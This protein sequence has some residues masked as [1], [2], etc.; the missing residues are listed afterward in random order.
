MKMRVFAA[1]PVPGPIREQLQLWAEE[2]RGKTAF[3]KWVHP[4]DYH[5]T[6]QFLG[7]VG[8]AKLVE[9]RAALQ[10]VQAAPFTLRLHGAGLFGP[11]KAPRVLW[12]AVAGQKEELV[13]L[14][15]KVLQA[16][17]PLGFV[18][19]D[20]PYAPHITLARTGETGGVFDRAALS[21]AP[22]GAQWTADRFVLMRT[23]MHASPMY[24]KLE[25]YFFV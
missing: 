18:P 9:L 25:E 3:R 16:T 1:V 5:I 15:G 11:L 21:T 24:E 13:S 22:S 19:E 6:L 17:Q 7:E 10:T 12:A 14:H 4:L 8:E 20:R 2:V 23:H